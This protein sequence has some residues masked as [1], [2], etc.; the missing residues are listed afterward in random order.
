VRLG[1]SRSSWYDLEKETIMIQLTPEQRQAVAGA[2]SLVLLDPET[3]QSY[4]LVRKEVFDRIKGLLYDDSEWTS[5]EQLR[6]LA[7]SGARAGWD[8]PEMDVY[9]NYEENRK[10]LCP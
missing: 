9:N 5:D 7:E 10:K 2:E 8:A 6:L 4:V 3:K 1:S